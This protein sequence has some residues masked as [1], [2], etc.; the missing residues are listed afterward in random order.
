M[1]VAKY[2]ITTQHGV[3]EGRIL[4]KIAK[5][6]GS[7][8]FMSKIWILMGKSAT[9]KDTIFKML[10]EQTEVPL[11]TIVPY[12]TRPIREG[13]REG[14]EYHFV[15]EEEYLLQKEA[16]KI[17]EQR[18]YETVHG[19]W[20]YF[21]VKDSQWDLEHHDYI[22]I[23]TLEGYEQVRAYFGDDVV[24]PIYITVEDGERLT[25]ALE[26]EK[27][28]KMP[29]YKELCRRYLADEEDFSQEKLEAAG[30]TC[31]YENCDSVECVKQIIEEI[32]VV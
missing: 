31:V 2:A 9:G 29:K 4:R 25:R 26:R 1:V 3:I 23:N 6:K 30:I 24:K 28:Q 22:M 14:V 17:I 10:K 13:E 27:Q 12:T 7:E 32:E 16:G 15:T 18:A 20:R 11:H 8:P 21:T 5:R 19:L